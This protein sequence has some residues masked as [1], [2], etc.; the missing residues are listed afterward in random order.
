MGG[1]LN[2]K[3][4]WDVTTILENLNRTEQDWYTDNYGELNDGVLNF[5]FWRNISEITNSYYVNATGSD[6]FS[7]AVRANFSAFN[8]GQ[9]TIARNLINSWDEV[10]GMSLR[11]TKSGDADIT[12]GNTATGGAQTYAYLPFGSGLY[13]T[14]QDLYDFSEVG[15]L[16]GDVWINGFVG[17]NFNPL[18]NSY[19]AVRA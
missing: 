5:G 13:Q 19:Y 2:G 11:E 3:P 6:Y 8:A 12:F 18:T 9:R 10:V 15:R 1:T 14:Y 17:S 16:G 4:I 7:E